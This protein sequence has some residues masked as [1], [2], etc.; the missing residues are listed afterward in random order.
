VPQYPLPFPGN[1]FIDGIRL[2]F[3]GPD[4]K[5]AFNGDG[6][7]TGPRRCRHTGLTR[8]G[9]YVIAPVDGRL[10]GQRVPST[11]P[12]A[13]SLL[14]SSD[15]DGIVQRAVAAAKKTRGI[16]RL[17]LSSYARMVI[18][19]ADLNGDIIG[20][21]RM[22]DATVFSIDVAVAKARN[23][24]WFSGAGTAD[25]RPPLRHGR[26]EPHHRLR[27][28]AALSSRHRL[29]GLHVGT[30]TVLS[31]LP[32][33][34]RQPPAARAR[35][36][37]M[38]IRAASSSSPAATPL[39]YSGGKLVGRS[40]RQWRLRRAGRLRDTT[41]AAASFLPD[42]KIWADRQTVNKVRLPMFKFPPASPR[43]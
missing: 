25:P 31:A 6:L 18:A 15:V 2:Q 40:R 21:Y 3:L 8:R 1:V 29:E 11:G 4:Q 23:V 34:P 7:P 43:E 12:K 36:R 28:T 38:R 9:T 32:S 39:P 37:R 22:P 13:G 19:V 30:G 26:D 27:R 24:I 16:I 10:C 33:R 20:L 5:L 42:K 41:S 14:S 35:S 17:P